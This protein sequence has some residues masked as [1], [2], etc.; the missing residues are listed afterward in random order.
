MN[1]IKPDSIV[2]RKHQD[3]LSSQLGDDLV[4]MDNNNGDY[5][6]FN[7]VANDIWKQL[8]SPAKVQDLIDYLLTK[9]N[10]SEQQCKAN[11]LAFLKQLQ[12]RQMLI[13]N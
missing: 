5:L 7:K 6:G 11:L 13:I 9:Y 3:L 4:F 2:K 12:K 8:E 10:V 1:R